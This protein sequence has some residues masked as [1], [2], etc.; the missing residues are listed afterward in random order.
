MPAC[1]V[2]TDAIKQIHYLKS[3]I[4][5]FVKEAQGDI[6]QPGVRFRSDGQELTDLVVGV[7]VL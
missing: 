1:L 7:R 2:L 4:S 5:I 3:N 6:E